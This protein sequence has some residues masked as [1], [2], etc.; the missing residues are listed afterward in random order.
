MNERMIGY[1]DVYC[2]FLGKAPIFWWFKKESV[3]ALSICESEY[4]VISMSA[5]QAAWL[6]SLMLELRI[7]EEEVVILMVNDKSSINLTKHLIAH[8]TNKHIETRFDFLRDEVTKGKLVLEHCMTKVQVGDAM[9][10]SLKIETFE[11]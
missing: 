10:K 6:D 7:K 8:R 9:K 1:S 5:C 2:F 11:N 4:I 3:V